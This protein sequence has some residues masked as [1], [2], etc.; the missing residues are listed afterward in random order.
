MA[1][2]FHE[3]VRIYKNVIPDDLANKAIEEIKWE[4][5]N[6]HTGERVPASSDTKG[7]VS[8]QGRNA[9]VPSIWEIRRLCAVKAREFLNCDDIVV[10]SERAN[11][12][13]G[14]TI[15]PWIHMD[16]NPWAR[17]DRKAAMATGAETSLEPN[18]IR[19][20]L[21]WTLISPQCRCM[22]VTRTQH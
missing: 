14:Q 4:K 6:P 8:L 3:L 11:W 19:S 16:H 12:T 20:N 22:H 2:A 18:Q 10:A 15:T 7:F 21:C 9:M 1:S 17:A 13:S 5:R